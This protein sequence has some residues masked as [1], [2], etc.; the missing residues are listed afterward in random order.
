MKRTTICVAFLLGLLSHL[1]SQTYTGTGGFISDDGLINDFT[2]DID[3]LDPDL[4][5]TDHGLVRICIH[6]NHT[7]IADL[8]IRLITPG[9]TNLMLA[10]ALGG[11]TDFYDN[12]CFDAV[13]GTH[14]LH[15]GP[16]YAGSYRPFSPLGN[17]NDGSSGNGIW[18][19]RILDTYAY[20][21]AGDV[22]EWSLTFGADAP[23]PHTFMGSNLPVI[24]LETGHITIPDEPKIPGTMKIFDRHDGYP[25]QLIDTPSFES[26]ITIEVRGSSSQMFPKKSFGFKTKKESGSNLETEL[27][28][29]PEEEDWILYASYNDKTFLRDAF[30]YHLGNATGHYTSRTQPCELFVNGDYHGIYFLEEK[31]K[32]DKNRVDIKKLNPADTLGD[33]LTGGYILKVDRDDGPGSYFVSQYPGT[34]ESGEIRIVYEDPDG[35]DLHPKQKDYIEQVFHDFEAALYGQNFA[36]PHLGYRRYMDVGSLLDFFIV[37]ELGHNVDAYRL[38]TFFYKDRNSVDSLFHLGPLWDFNLAY[39]NVDY[40]NCQYIE[41]WAYQNSG[42]CGNTPR[43]WERFLQDAY[44]RDRLRCRYDSLRETVLSHEA[45]LGYVGQ[46]AEILREA[47]VRNFERWP[48]LGM[49]IWPNFFI[50][51]TFDQE[52]GYM[53]EWL[54]GRLSWLDENMPGE[55]TPVSALNELY[56]SGFDLV[57]NPA[58]STVSIRAHTSGDE[59]MSVT[60]AGTNGSR[61]FAQTGIY[62]G[63]AL[64][65]STLVPGLYIVTII[66][67]GGTVSQHRLVTSR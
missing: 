58:S 8:D 60:I 49:Y 12:T 54:N 15:G 26:R 45:V 32:R 50:G 24:A 62:P 59:K 1:Q 47:Q 44:F 33:A 13:S 36:D 28:G 67:D 27:L 2:L 65:I 34:D 16:P 19:L 3:G 42:A 5:N 57:P 55:C 53:A 20:A 64:D 14:I 40:C 63:Q 17:A 51:Q 66:Q 11:D 10:S 6:I 39:G 25:N 52:V 38:S 18:T 35:E 48:I 61:V 43:W 41:G 46:Q 9:G 30:T 31:I 29:F 7:W 23:A 22:L 4:L 37:S 21:D 56:T